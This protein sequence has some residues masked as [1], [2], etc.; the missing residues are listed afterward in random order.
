[1]EDLKEAK[2]LAIDMAK[3]TNRIHFIIK[4]AKKYRIITASDLSTYDI[5]AA[6]VRPIRDGETAYVESG[7]E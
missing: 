5:I 3:E 4:K 6:T 1:M 7:Y 2:D